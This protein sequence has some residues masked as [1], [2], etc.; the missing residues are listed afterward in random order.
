L[1]HKQ[2]KIKIF[3]FFFFLV[4][5]RISLWIFNLLKCVTL[6]EFSN[7]I[8]IT[9]EFLFKNVSKAYISHLEI[10]YIL[11]K[12]CNVCN[13]WNIWFKLK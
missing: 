9:Q 5:D 3:Y 10:R 8:K 12:S 13:N 6:N 1:A 7:K 2:I 4:S 11:I